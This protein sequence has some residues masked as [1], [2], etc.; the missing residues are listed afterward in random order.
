MELEV[1]WGRGGAMVRNSGG[2]NSPDYA[3][4]GNSTGV[5]KRERTITR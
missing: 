1:G 5:S 4:N 3:E 2:R